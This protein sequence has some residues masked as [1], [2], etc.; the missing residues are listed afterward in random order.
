MKMPGVLLFKQMFYEFYVFYKI[1]NCF[2]LGIYNLY[3]FTEIYEYC[4]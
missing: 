2:I 4:Q 3:I 1:F